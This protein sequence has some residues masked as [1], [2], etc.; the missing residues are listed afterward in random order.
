M[1][2]IAYGFE[3]RVFGLDRSQP[4]HLKASNNA[5]TVNVSSK[6]M[7]NWMK[8]LLCFPKIRFEITEDKTNIQANEQIKIAVPMFELSIDA[9]DGAEAVK[10]HAIVDRAVL[11]K[12]W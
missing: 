4:N 3:S 10:E 9:R 2:T 5:E 1:N 12:I 8:I 7:R 11:V 6:L